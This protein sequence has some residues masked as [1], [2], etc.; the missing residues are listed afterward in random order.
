V[1]GVRR[2][3]RR[4]RLNA[5]TLG[6]ALIATPLLHGLSFP[7]WG[8]WGLAWVALVPWF[9]AVRLASTTTRALL[10]T[11]VTT[12][13]GTW[14]VATWLP[15]AIATTWGQPPHVGAALFVGVWLVAVAPAAVVFT[16]CYRAAALRHG[17]SMAFVAGA[18]WAGTE[19]ARV[20]LGIGNP[21]AL[22]GYS[23]APVSSLI[24]IADVT[25]VYGVSFAVAAVNAALAEAWLAWR[26][27][28]RP[29]AAAGALA[30]A[31]AAVGLCLGYDAL[32]DES[33]A[34]RPPQ[35]VA[36]AQANLRPDEPAE[37]TLAEHVALGQEA[38]APRRP[39]LLVWS[40]G[41]T[42]VVLDDA[43]GYR[44]SIAR[45][46]APV[47][48]ELL[49]GGVRVTDDGGSPRWYDT[50]VLLAPSGE[51]AGRLDAEH[52]P[53]LPEWLP[54]GATGV[55]ARA[56]AAL[57][58]STPGPPTPP[59]TTRIGA[60]GVM[61]G[62]EAMFPRVAARRVRAGA[63]FLV[64]LSDD[65]WLGD[66]QLALQRLD[67]ARLRAIEQR[68]DVIRASTSGPSAVIDAE[69]TI[70][71]KTEPLTR[72]TLAGTVEPRVQRSFYAMVGDGFAISCAAV[73]V[74][75]LLSGLGR[76]RRRERKEPAA[77]VHVLPPKKKIG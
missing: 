69:G 12:L 77:P 64:S 68:R 19:F 54:L 72:A 39:A 14:V 20:E 58:A 31:L 36:V 43:Q 17:A 75:E 56:L 7:P 65:A 47:D 41:A 46:L 63:E 34:E 61:V 53:L 24:Q 40:E 29:M 13:G 22:L 48:V 74:L 1:D 59:L 55:L 52:P 76:W 35:R 27:W 2:R 16:L 33:E 4:H 18:A 60:A 66:R 51:V 28:A 25:G 11:C 15:R 8:L 32:R 71:A 49:A 42:S 37:K 26:G 10:I 6:L 5:L 21:F 44:E 3:D 9:A 57:R 23:Q 50:A 73:V 30:T 45:V 62:N 38:L 70:G 67:A